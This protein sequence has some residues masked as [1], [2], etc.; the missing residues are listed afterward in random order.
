M[1]TYIAERTLEY[2]HLSVVI[3]W[4]WLC[5]NTYILYTYIV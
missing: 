2:I 1:Q 3:V 5:V 4:Q